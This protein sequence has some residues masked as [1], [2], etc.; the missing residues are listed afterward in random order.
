MAYRNGRGGMSP[1]DRAKQFMTFAALKGY[2]EA[3]RRK[4][5][6]TVPKAELSEERGE[7]LDRTLRQV[8]KN[9]MVTVIYFCDGEYLK[10]TGMVS[11]I[12]GTARL[13]KIVDTKVPFEDLYEVSIQGSV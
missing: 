9:D 2:E 10:V 12:D 7:E 6:I 1:Q 5:K 3:L 13:L 11:R 4:E 8:R